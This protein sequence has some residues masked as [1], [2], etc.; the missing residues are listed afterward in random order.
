MTKLEELK[1]QEKEL[2]EKLTEK[3]LRLGEAD[4]PR[5]SRYPTERFE[6]ENLIQLLELQL[7]DVRKQFKV[8]QASSPKS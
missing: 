5:E 2:Q 6:L 8:V 3:R 1:Q 7:Q 4:G